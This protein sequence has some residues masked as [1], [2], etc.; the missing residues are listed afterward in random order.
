MSADLG[1][2]A[3]SVS[4]N[5]WAREL[6]AS[7]AGLSWT[8]MDRSTAIAATIEL[9]TAP[10]DSGGRST[11]G[12]AFRRSGVRIPSGPQISEYEMALARMPSLRAQR[13][14]SLF[15]SFSTVYWRRRK[16]FVRS[17]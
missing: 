14:G 8:L 5:N 4:A 13:V 7:R 1:S 10:V 12:M 2:T 9:E 17:N 3:L 6:T 16:W 11:V 15:D